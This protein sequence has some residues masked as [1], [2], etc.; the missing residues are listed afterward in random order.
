MP[1][2][3]LRYLHGLDALEDRP[4]QGLDGPCLR[5]VGEA[6]ILLTPPASPSLLKRLL[7]GETGAA[8]GRS[9][10]APRLSPS[11]LKRLLLKGEAGAAE[12]R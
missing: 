8:E 3:V 9:R 2:W 11:L 12:G 10:L 5:A 7:K 1:L 6:V 4:D